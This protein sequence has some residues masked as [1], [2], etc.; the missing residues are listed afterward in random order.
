[1]H[2]QKTLFKTFI[3]ILNMII[4]TSYL[5]LMLTRVMG[6]SHSIPIPIPIQFSVTKY[7]E[8]IQNLH[9]RLTS[10]KHVTRL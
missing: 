10:R 4:D 3:Y 8:E 1:M 2:V 5:T 6:Q 7:L 9:V